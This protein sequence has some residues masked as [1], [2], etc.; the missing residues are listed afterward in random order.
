MLALRL[1]SKN[2]AKFLRL[3]NPTYSGGRKYPNTHHYHIHVE[4]N[5]DTPLAQL[6][7]DLLKLVKPVVVR[8]PK[9]KPVPAPA[10]PATLPTPIKKEGPAK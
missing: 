6:S 10:T 2:P 5:V 4:L 9:P 8:K 3:T 7:K 1:A